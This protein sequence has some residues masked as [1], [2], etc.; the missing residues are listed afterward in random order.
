MLVDFLSRDGVEV[1]RFLGTDA[2]NILP[3]KV[4][5][6]HSPR[7]RLHAKAYLFNG[8]MGQYAA[9][10]SSNLTKSGL[11]ENSELNLASYSPEL[12]T[13]LEGWFDQKWGAWPGL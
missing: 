6:H 2:G 5:D 8:E 3:E 11:A 1:R 9:V 13:V 12:T 10:G 7:N 4:L